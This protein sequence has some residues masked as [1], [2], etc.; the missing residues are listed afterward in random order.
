MLRD[1]DGRLHFGLASS[2]RRSG[3]SG[4]LRISSLVRGVIACFDAVGV[5]AEIGI[6]VDD[7]RLAAGHREQVLV[8]HEVRIEEDRFVAGIDGRQ[9]R[10]EQPAADAAGDEHFAD[11]AA[12]LGGQILAQPLA[13]R[14]DALGLRVAIVARA[15]RLD[16]GVLWPIS[17]TS[18]SGRPIERLIGSFIFAA[19]SKTLRMPEASTPWA[20]REM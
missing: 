18:K 3:C 15:D 17:G 6:A 5:E 12:D 1:L 8:H 16:R 9:D 4:E 10:Q 20:R 13:Q 11:V 7:D 19:R 14:G 2:P